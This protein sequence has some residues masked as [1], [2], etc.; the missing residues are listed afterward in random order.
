MKRCI[1]I[2]LS[3]IYVL[4]S[5]PDLVAFYISPSLI[6]VSFSPGSQ[7]FRG[8]SSSHLEHRKS[9]SDG[10]GRAWPTAAR[11][12]DG[13]VRGGREGEKNTLA[14]ECGAGRA[15]YIEPV[16]PWL[17][18]RPWQPTAGGVLSLWVRGAQF[19]RQRRAQRKGV[20]R[21]SRDSP[22]AGEVRW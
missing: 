12:G 21:A 4:L 13:N 7:L 8:G 18:C 2:L 22:G 9:D 11:S 15:L 20:R 14:E 16:W 1:L 19:V 6:T 17:G 3:L 5:M 10:Y